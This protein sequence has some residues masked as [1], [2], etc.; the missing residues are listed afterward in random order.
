MTSS[1]DSENFIDALS[2]LRHSLLG[3]INAEQN[4]LLKD[5]CFALTFLR[6]LNCTQSEIKSVAKIKAIVSDEVAQYSKVC[7]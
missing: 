6:N 7:S 1:L 4:K 3:K 5:L 2:L